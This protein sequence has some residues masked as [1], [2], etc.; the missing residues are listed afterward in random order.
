MA[1]EFLDG[2]DI[3]A[4]FQQM[5]RKRMPQ[6]M[7]AAAFLEVGPPYSVL[8]RFLEHTMRHMVPTF[9]ARG[10]MARFAAGKTYCHSQA[11]PAWGSLRAKA[12]GKCT[13]P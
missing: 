13:S 12:Y 7:T 11:V 10:S 6:G 2:P 4:I 3:I 9:D 1:Q 5:G 8:H